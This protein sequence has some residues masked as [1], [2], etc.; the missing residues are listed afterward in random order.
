MRKR[1]YSFLI[2]LSVTF[3]VF[4]SLSVE[5]IDNRDYPNDGYDV[6]FLGDKQGYLYLNDTIA[7][8]RLD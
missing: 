2:F 8:E 6:Y 1:F 7:F 4:I 5:I 3:I